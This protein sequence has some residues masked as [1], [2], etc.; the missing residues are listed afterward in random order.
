MTGDFT[1]VWKE[2]ISIYS[3]QNKNVHFFQIYFRLKISNRIMIN[4][5]IGGNG[6]F[7]NNDVI[8]AN[9]LTKTIIN[10]DSRFRSNIANSTTSSFTYAFEH[11]IKNIIRAKITSIEIPNVWYEFSLQNY[12][13]TRFTICAYDYYDDRQTGVITI[14]NGNYTPTT[15]LSTIQDR[16]TAFFAPL[17]IF[18]RII[19]DPY[20]LKVSIIFD[21]ICPPGGS[22]PTLSATPF[23]INFSVP[24]LL[25]LR[26]YNNGIGYNLGYR[27]TFYEGTPVYDTSGGITS[28]YQ[29][30]ESLIDTQGLT[31]CFLEISDIG[32]NVQH[33]S[34]EKYTVALAK[35]LVKSEKNTVMFDGLETNNGTSPADFVFT[36]PKNLRQ[37]QVKLIDMFGQVIDLNDMNFSFT[38]E[39][40]DVKN[41]RLFEYYRNYIWLGHIPAL[42]VNITGSGTPLLGGRGP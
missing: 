7:N 2:G 35:I 34:Y 9:D 33:K 29:P 11:E 14:P 39:L 22:A 42:P 1:V 12:Q 40:T 37:I 8:N 25:C 27:G 36:S 13:N 4:S 18:I 15:L 21:G 23:Y 31:Y 32:G 30:A 10:I 16:I 17:G 26:P 3:L 20:S 28:Y 24:P 6:I 41:T 19:R 38:L 5:R